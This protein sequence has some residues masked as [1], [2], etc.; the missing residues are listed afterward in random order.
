[1]NDRLIEIE[2]KLAFQDHAIDELGQIIV[3]QD[4]KIK[5]L[6]NKLSMIQ[7]QLSDEELVR[8]QEDEAPPPHY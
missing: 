4:K 6:E 2:K 5:A 3:E 1:M 7:N 8:P